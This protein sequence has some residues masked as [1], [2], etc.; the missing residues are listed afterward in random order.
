MV[1]EMR[2]Y[3]EPVDVG[4]DDID[5]AVRELY[6]SPSARSG[7][8]QASQTA[9]STGTTLPARELRPHYLKMAAQAFDSYAR[10][11]DARLA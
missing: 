6:Q 8:P 2:L 7:D 4:G 3:L 1:A 10:Q 9:S 11:L 5:A